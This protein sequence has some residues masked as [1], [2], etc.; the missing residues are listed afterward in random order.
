[1][2]A[3]NI[4]EK[5]IQKAHC[6]WIKE[7][8]VELKALLQYDNETVILNKQ[9]ALSGIETAIQSLEKIRLYINEL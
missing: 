4:S 3:K 1:M 6:D 7:Q 2:K 5:T 8:A 9:R